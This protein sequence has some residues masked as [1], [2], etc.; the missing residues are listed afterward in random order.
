MAK[1]D[2]ISEILSRK[3]RLHKRGGRW[4]LLSRKLDPLADCFNFLLAP[5]LVPESVRTEL[6]RYL[7][8]AHIAVLEGYFRLAYAELI[9]HGDPYLT[10][11]GQFKEIKLSLEPIIGLHKRDTTTGELIAHFLPHNSASDIENNMTTLLGHS[12]RGALLDEEFIPSDATAGVSMRELD[13]P[14]WKGLHRM[15]ELRHVVCHELATKSSFRLTA[16]QELCQ[17]AILFIIV[18]DTYICKRLGQKPP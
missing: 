18:S 2:Y 8:V 1:R 16:I 3:Q 9:N 6:I 14:V 12:F 17:I 7:P 13:E 4:A 11:A 15:F 10:N 5:G